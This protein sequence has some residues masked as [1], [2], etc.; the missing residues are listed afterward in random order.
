M[1]NTLSFTDKKRV[2][3][4]FG[5]LKE[6]SKFPNLIEIQKN[7]YDEFLLENENPSS[8]EDRGLQKVFKSVFPLEDFSG[9]ARI[10]FIDYNFQKPKFDVDECRQRDKTYAAPLNVKLRLIVFDIDEETET[11]TVKDI[12]EQEIYL[13]DLPLMT[14]KGTFITNGTERVVVSQMHRS[15]GVFFDH[16]NGKTH[17][18]GKL[19]FGARVIPYRG[20]WLDIEFDHKDILYCRID[21][22]K[23]ILVTSFLMS[24][25]I[26]RDEILKLFY[27]IEEFSIDKKS[28]K[29]KVSFN[30]KNIKTGKLQKNLINASDGKVAI[31]QGTKINPAIAQKLFK[32]GLKNILIEKDDLIGKFIAEDII[33][34]TYWRNLL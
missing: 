19:L 5:K 13:C 17:S 23:K 25:G 30:P 32:D 26:K 14:E 20:S 2:R 7:S 33:N 1:V 28:N 24:M 8:R 21:R 4:N 16:D 27:N 3:K 12:K 34:E 18:S 6:V 9:S 22:K 29:W 11:R 15:P 31:K 10:E